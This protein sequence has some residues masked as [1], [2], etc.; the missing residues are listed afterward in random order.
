MNIRQMERPGAASVLSQ[1]LN[2]G[3]SQGLTKSG[4]GQVTAATTPG[5][6]LEP[7]QKSRPK[8]RRCSCGSG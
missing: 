5:F 3:L 2:R 8:F 6:P 7:G 1:G 4:P